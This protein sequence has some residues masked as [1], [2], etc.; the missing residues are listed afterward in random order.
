MRYYHESLLGRYRKVT[1]TLRWFIFLESRESKTTRRAPQY[2]W[3]CMNRNCE[4]TKSRTEQAD[5]T[6][7]SVDRGHGWHTGLS[8]FRRLVGRFRRVAGTRMEGQK[9]RFRR[10]VRRSTS[11]KSGQTDGC[12]YVCACGQETGRA[13]MGALLGEG[14]RRLSICAT[15]GEASQAK[16]EDDEQG[17]R[18]TNGIAGEKSRG[19]R[20]GHG[21]SRRSGWL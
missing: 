6:Q 12:A 13:I 17:E 4:S 3:D 7:I 16:I 5:K 19:R 10:K 18:K 21:L 14:Q 2:M 15:R 9:S 20:K 1:E 11:R 8:T